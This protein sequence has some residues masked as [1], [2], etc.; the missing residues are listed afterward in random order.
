MDVLE[1]E[2]TQ[3]T[4][5]G[6]GGA[7]SARVEGR[8]NAYA[9]RGHP[10]AAAQTAAEALGA[11]AGAS[12][13]RRQRGA[14]GWRICV[15]GPRGERTVPGTA[16]LNC[17]ARLAPSPGSERKWTTSALPIPP[18]SVRARV[19]MI[20]EIHARCTHGCTY[21]RL[22]LS[23]RTSQHGRPSYSSDDLVCGKGEAAASAADHI[24]SSALVVTQPP[25]TAST[26]ASSPAHVHD[27]QPRAAALAVMGSPCDVSA[28]LELSAA[29]AVL[30]ALCAVGAVSAGAEVV[31][32]AG[33]EDEGE[34]A[35]CGPLEGAALVAAARPEDDEDDCA[36]PVDAAD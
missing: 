25:A 7:R 3:E 16:P 12:R 9:A 2:R 6:A 14:R 15:R 27:R 17:A 11:V 34:A 23:P 20:I 28:M 22:L 30:P 21:N 36:A 29:A 5:E 33:G 35:V 4:G 18:P 8:G 19:A 1:S 13:R 31:E 10:V 24:A 32:D 26:A